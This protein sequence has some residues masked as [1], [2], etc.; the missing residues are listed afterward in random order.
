MKQNHAVSF[1][2]RGTLAPYPCSLVGVLTTTEGLLSFAAHPQPETCDVVEVRLGEIPPASCNWQQACRLIQAAGIP[3]LV[4]PRNTLEGGRLEDAAPERLSCFADALTCAD[5]LD[6]EWG[7]ALRDEVLTLASKHGMATILSYHDF[8]RTPSGGELDA[9]LAAMR[10]L[11]PQAILKVAAMVRDPVDVTTL[12]TALN[13]H[14]QP[15]C[16][17]GMG[18][19]GAE[20]RTMLPRAGSC[21]AYAWLDAPSAPGQPS[22]AELRQTITSGTPSNAGKR[23]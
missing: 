1:P 12:Q 23:P 15:V 13:N 20:T 9:L 19:P 18:S 4:T 21:L 16:L 17:I 7:S 10:L 8:A 5:A 14:P 2:R 11:A 6:I 22:C 3:V